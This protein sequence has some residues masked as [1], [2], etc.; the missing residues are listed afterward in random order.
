MFVLSRCEEEGVLAPLVDPWTGRERAFV[1]PPPPS[2]HEDNDAGGRRRKR[3]ERGP[4]YGDWETTALL[5]KQYPSLFHAAA[6]IGGF[7]EMMSGIVN[8]RSLTV[9][10]TGT[11]GLGGGGGGGAGGGW[12]KTTVEYAL[13]S[14]S[15]ALETAKMESL[16]RLSLLHVHVRGLRALSSTRRNDQGRASSRDW[17]RNVRRLEMTV[18]SDPGS[19]SRDSTTLH[20]FLIGFSGLQKFD[21]RWEGERDSSPMPLYRTS[22][23]ACHPATRRTHRYQQHDTPFPLLTHLVIDN[24][25]MSA[26]QIQD[27]LVSHWATLEDLVLESIALTGGT[28][29]EALA[30]LGDIS[31][32]NQWRDI[33]EEMGEVPIMLAPSMLETPRKKVR[34]TSNIDMR[35]SPAPP[36]DARNISQEDKGRSHLSGDT[37]TKRVRTLAECDNG[38]A[39]GVR[40]LLS[41]KEET[42]K[43]KTKRKKCDFRACHNV[44]KAVK[45][46]LTRWRL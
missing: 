29:D 30:P 16:T 18:L 4:R 14:L 11:D 10:C 6:D 12:M 44:L 28:W 3:A 23:T 42:V 39:E 22:D 8:L 27:I 26:K 2:P 46:G 31:G 15:L 34:I 20:E 17:R 9:R 1:F 19:G 13:V 43:K 7:E 35:S 45:L 25:I 38:V 21:F 5:I 40:T 36:R 32:Y 24:A 37:T 41:S 33:A